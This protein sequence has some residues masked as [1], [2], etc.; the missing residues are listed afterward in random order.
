M[1]RK[2]RGIGS[3]SSV[4]P[5]KKDSKIRCLIYNYNNILDKYSQLYTS[6]N[7]ILYIKWD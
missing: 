6:L 2:K 5:T 1:S 4:N 3:T 7:F